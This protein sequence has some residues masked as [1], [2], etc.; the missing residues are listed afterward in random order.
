MIGD[1]F[2][3]ERGA[4]L[5]IGQG[6]EGDGEWI[7]DEICGCTISVRS[8]E[9]ILAVWNKSGTDERVRVRIRCVLSSSLYPVFLTETLSCYRD[10]IR[11]VLGLQSGT[12]MEYK[13]NNGA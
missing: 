10:I 3:P 1:Q 8:N 12:T 7:G 6:G 2:A 5:G 9:D 11:K 13:S 4:V